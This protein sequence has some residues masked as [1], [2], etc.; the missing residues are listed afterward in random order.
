MEIEIKA[1]APIGIRE[2][3]RN[4]G[5]A[6]SVKVIQRDV[7]FNHPQRDFEETDEALRIRYEDGRTFMTY[8]GPKV[9]KKTKTREEIEF[10]ID[11]GRKA[12]SMLEK[13]GFRR[14]VE[15]SKRRETYILE[16]I[17]IC[18]DD[19][20][21]LGFF[22][23]IETEGYDTEENRKKLFEIGDRLGLKNYIRKSYLEMILKNE[24]DL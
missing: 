4:L 24:K 7:Y 23:E 17:R 8:K 12:E 20:E 3:L 1:R 16:G 2:T 15:V 22:V 11:D 19:V 14:S 9:D 5:A 10:S 21:K 18:L 6:P 13:L